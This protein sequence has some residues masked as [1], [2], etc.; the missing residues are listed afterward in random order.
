MGYMGSQ[1]RNRE[2]ATGPDPSG[3]QCVEGVETLDATTSTWRLGNGAVEGLRN[4]ISIT[5]VRTFDHNVWGRRKKN[6]C[7]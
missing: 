7:R 4:K 1:L 2:T 3:S 5:R 6:S